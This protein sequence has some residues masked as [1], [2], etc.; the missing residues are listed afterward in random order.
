MLKMCLYGWLVTLVGSAASVLAQSYSYQAPKPM[1]EGSTTM[2]WVMVFI[3]LI[4]A[5]VVGFKPAK[6]SNLK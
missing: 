2:E 3:F 1:N 4:G 6:R 5:L